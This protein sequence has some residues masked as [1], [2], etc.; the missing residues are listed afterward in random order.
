M[1]A[2][3]M[4][5]Y[6]VLSGLL[7]LFLIP[8]F[9]TRPRGRARLWQRFGSWNISENRQ[10]IWLHGAS[11]GEISALL[12]LI[13][14]TRERF[15]KFAILVTATSVTGL[16]TAKLEADHVRLLPFDS[17]WW[18]AR[19]FRGLNVA[20]CLIAETEIWPAMLY[21]ASTRNIPVCYV[22]ARISKYSWPTYK[23]FRIILR[24]LLNDISHFYIGDAFS[25]LCFFEIGIPKEKLS[26]NGSTKYDSGLNPDI[27]SAGEILRRTYFIG[28]GP[29]IVLG[30]LRPGEEQVWFPAIREC[31]DRFPQVGFI[32]AP[33]HEEK[34]EYFAE[35]LKR[36]G[37][38]YSR[39]SCDFVEAAHSNVSVL[40]LDTFGKLKVAYAAG[41]AAFIGG[42]LTD[43][44][45]HNA[46]EAASYKCALGLG[47]FRSNIMDVVDELL[48]QNA[49]AEIRS[50][51]EAVAFVEM[52]VTEPDRVSA[53]ADRAF[54]VWLKS[55]GASSRIVDSMYAVLEGEKRAD[56]LGTGSSKH[57]IAV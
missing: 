18:F 19:A 51:T 11:I 15:P 5:T 9:L 50:T 54:A 2:L 57:Q 4:Q 1:K 17:S 43:I 34:F 36:A 12:P 6:S 48:Q 8:L 49:F 30:S 52:V 56:H 26:L 27:E 3:L 23:K 42:T 33:R 38:F 24:A 14:E 31:L 53:M 21:F 41:D 35:S 45:G 32:V 10:I 16:D 13:R 39:W 40:L 28:K 29:L 44:G 46:L 7:S 20:S 25:N 55:Q 47:P 22:N 37:I